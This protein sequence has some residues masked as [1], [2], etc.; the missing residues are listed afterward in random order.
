MK[1][2]LNIN[3]FT[4]VFITSLLEVTENPNENPKYLMYSGA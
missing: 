2:N 4:S 1:L 3:Y